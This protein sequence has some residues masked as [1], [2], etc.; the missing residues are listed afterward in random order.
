MRW[1]KRFHRSSALTITRR[2]PGFRT[3]RFTGDA[4]QRRSPAPPVPSTEV[5]GLKPEAGSP[6][7][8]TGSRKPALLSGILTHQYHHHPCAPHPHHS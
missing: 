2:R 4:P 7:P 3:R 6:K 5:K 8:E 1:K